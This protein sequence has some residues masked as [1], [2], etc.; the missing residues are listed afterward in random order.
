MHWKRYADTVSWVGRDMAHLNLKWI[1]RVTDE[2][3]AYARTPKPGRLLNSLK[4]R[5]DEDFGPERI[6][7]N[8]HTCVKVLHARR[9]NAPPTSTNGAAAGPKHTM[10]SGK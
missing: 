2:N 7:P 1:T 3:R 4:D 6:V 5:K 10:M 9:K 8:D